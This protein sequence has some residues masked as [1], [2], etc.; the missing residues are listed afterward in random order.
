MSNIYEIAEKVGLSPST[1]ARA[2]SGR[3]Y[4]SSESRRKVLEAAKELNYSPTHAAKTLKSKRTNKIL[5]CIPDIYNPFYFGMIK[6]ANDVLEEYGYYTLLCHTKHNI[7]EE[8]KMIDVLREKYGDGMIF[9]SFHFCE[10]NIGAVNASEMPIVLT[11]RYDSPDGNDNFDYVYVDTYMGVQLATRHLAEQG[12]R[13][14]AFIGGSLDEQTSFERYSGWKDELV[15]SGL[16]PDDELVYEGDY[17]IE[18]GYSCAERIVKSSHVPTGIVAANDLMAIGF[19]RYCDDHG[20]RIPEDFAVVG[21]D[22]T[23]FSTVI[24][25]TSI[26]MRQEEIGLNA[27]SLLMERILEGRTCKKTIRIEPKLVVR[28]SSIPGK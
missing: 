4:C 1:V 24:R 22:N 14:I 9:V 10:E 3:G 18:S 26:N 5:F 16:N 20:I 11:N 7:E 28:E 13:K 8:L 27:A 17:T 12:H 2:L 15:E 23:D 6:G 19:I 21:M 25:L